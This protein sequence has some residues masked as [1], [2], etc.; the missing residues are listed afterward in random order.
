MKTTDIERRTVA[1]GIALGIGMG[2]FIDGILFHQILQLHNMLSAQLPVTS[3]RNA[4]INMFWDGIF[5][6]V[7]WTATAVGI[8]QLWRTA[9]QAHLT[10][11][12]R[13]FVGALLM[14]CGLFNAVEGLLSHVVFGL[15]H[16]VEKAGL[17][18]FDAAL[19]AAGVVMVA[20]GWALTRGALAGRNVGS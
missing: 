16:V 5:H 10:L 15:H 20:G 11:P 19:L 4:E 1:A 14:G 17:S 18:G 7:T 8:A 13:G 3:L 12:T 2:G 6:A 9:S